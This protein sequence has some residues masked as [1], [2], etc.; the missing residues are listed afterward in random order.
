MSEMIDISP[1][2]CK[3]VSVQNSLLDA[4]NSNNY[5]YKSAEIV[6]VCGDRTFIVRHET[7]RGVDLGDFISNAAKLCVAMCIDCP[8]KSSNS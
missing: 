7:Q 6:T 1:E 4:F 8:R 2:G 3:A 5:S